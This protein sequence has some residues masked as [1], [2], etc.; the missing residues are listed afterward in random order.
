[1]LCLLRPPHL[2]GSAGAQRR[3]SDSRFSFGPSVGRGPLVKGCDGPSEG[4]STPSSERPG[5]RLLVPVGFRAVMPCMSRRAAVGGQ[6]DGGK[7][8]RLCGRLVAPC[9]VACPAARARTACP[10][11]DC[12]PSS[13]RDSGARCRYRRGG[14][15]GLPWHEARF[16]GLRPPDGVSETASVPQ[17]L[18]TRGGPGDRSRPDT[19][20][21]LVVSLPLPPLV[22]Q[23]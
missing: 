21:D 12:R 9:A 4:A 15:G 14:R 2:A 11:A 18:P 1:M 6:A 8:W 16:A 17:A 10:G 23:R 22:I 13:F 5:N 19:T 3:E 20:A 7:T